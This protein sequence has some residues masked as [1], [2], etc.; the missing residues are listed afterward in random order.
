MSDRVIWVAGWTLL[1]A[2]LLSVAA[3]VTLADTTTEQTITEGA[4][5]EC[6]PVDVVLGRSEECEGWPTGRAMPLLLLTAA[7]AALGVPE[8]RRLALTRLAASLG[9]VVAAI[10]VL[11]NLG[12]LAFTPRVWTFRLV[13]GV[14]A[15]GFL[16]FFLLPFALRYDVVREA[17]LERSDQATT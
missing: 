8:G 14:L 11:T 17:K 7:V 4:V 10:V 6:R 5:A 12:D 16:P 13:R 3:I 1:L 2:V 9:V 15:A